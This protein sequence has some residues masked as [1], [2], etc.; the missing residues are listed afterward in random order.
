MKAIKTFFNPTIVFVLFFLAVGCER[1]KWQ[2]QLMEDTKRQCKSSDVQT[3][4][5]SFLGDERTLTNAL[6]KL[7]SS[8]P[9]FAEDFTHIKLAHA[10]STNDLMLEIGGGFGHWGLIVVKPGHEKEI[11]EW[12]RKRMVFWGDGVFFFFFE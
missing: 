11:S 5:A 9:I 7:I 2:K 3:A 12:H 8:L 1:P 6:P 4:L 10:D